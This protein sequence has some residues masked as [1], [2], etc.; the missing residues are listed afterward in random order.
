MD[1]VFYASNLGKREPRV[2]A[3][4]ITDGEGLH[5]ERFDRQARHWVHDARVAGFLTGHDDWAERVTRGSAQRI[6]RSWGCSPTV[7]SAPLAE[8]LTT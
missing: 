8:V 3:R 2:L 1:V 5:A 7:L 6:L 4:F